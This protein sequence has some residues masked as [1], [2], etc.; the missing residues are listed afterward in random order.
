MTRRRTTDGLPWLALC[1]LGAAVL[2]GCTGDPVVGRGDAGGMDAPDVGLVC[3]TPQTVCANRC[4]DLQSDPTNCGACGRSCADGMVCTAGVCQVRCPAGATVCGGTCVNTQT[5]NANCGACGRPC[6]A[7]QVCSLG[8]CGTTCAASLATCAGGDAGSDAGAAPFCADLANDR[9]NCGACGTACPPGNICVA[10]ACQLSCAAGQ[11][12]CGAACADLQNDNAHCGTCGTACPAGTACVAGACAVSCGAGLAQCGSACVNLQTD[13]THCGACGTACPAG[14]VCSAGACSTTCASPL[15]TCSGTS[16][17]FCANTDL[18]PAHCGSCGTA[19]ALPNVAANGCA[20]GACGV[21]RCSANFGDCDGTAA[22]GCETDTRTALAHCG[23]CGRACAL[24]HATASCAAGACTVMACATGFADCDGVAA[25]GCEVNTG[26]E[27]GN[28]GACG[29][30]CPA[31]QVCSNGACGA[32]CA[33]PLATCTTAGATSCANTQNDPAHCGACNA[34]C[35]LANAAVQTCASGRCTVASC[36][37]SFGDCDGMSANGCETDTRTAVANCGGCGRACSLANATSTCA[38]G[39]CAV[40]A[41]AT[42]FA[43]CDGMAANGCEVA[44]PTDNANCGACGRACGAGQVCSAGSCTATCASPLATCGAGS[45]QFCANTLVDPANCGACGAACSLS[46]AAAT[47]CAAGACTVLRCNALAGD[48]DG[49]ASNG[50]ETNLATSSAHCGACGRACAL[51]NATSS[52]S[53]GG[54]AVTA[55]AANFANCDM[56]AAN[57]CEVNTQSDNANCGG[58]GTTCPAGQLCAG[59]ACTTTCAAPLTLCSGACVNTTNDPMRCGSCTNVCPTPAH[60]IPVC[61]A[62][63]CAF[64]CAAGYGDCDR[65]ASNGCEVDL[66]STAASCGSCTGACPARANATSTCAS[67]TCGYVCSAGAADCDSMAANG[68]E[69]NTNT[70]TNCGGCGRVCPTYANATPTCGS[71]TCGSTCNA[72]F[73]DCDGDPTNGCASTQ[74]DAA[75]CGSCGHACTTGQSCLG[76][77]CISALSCRSIKAANPLA[78]DG[79]YAIDPDGAGGGAAFNV[80]CEMTTD[81]GGWTVMAYIRSNAQWDIPTFMNSGTPGDVAGGFAQGATLQAS[82]ATFTDRIII[83]RRLIENGSDL[84]AQWMQTYRTDGTPVRYSGYNVEGGW[85]YRD[86][87]GYVD[88][89]VDSICS[90]GCSSFRG[91]GMFHAFESGFG[92][93]GTQT[94]NYG[95]RDG[96]NICWM[97]RSGGC[98]VG[99]T[100]CS[101]LTGPGEGVIYAG[102]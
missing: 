13:N 21:V 67:T 80:Y 92:Y 71:G 58:C 22:N 20:G 77:A 34:A 63:A 36:A 18:D 90:H 82:A 48:C 35:A 23:G 37:A 33:S 42:G 51:P 85:S 66:S 94:G 101:L 46:G 8:A 62:G 47:G 102:R 91:L 26:T 40:M 83:Y 78:T 41:C 86:S 3:T 81:G 9:L 30:V 29:T 55:C 2:A 52:C 19:C 87:F 24:P 49:T 60:A 56:M 39:A 73:G 99:D 16:G 32:T 6:A 12:Q 43:D 54:C 28:C 61:A 38:A 65:N 96:N 79:V 68:C 50:C 100:R 75:N 11:S 84:G 93:A 1:V 89:S 74:S 44:L 97:P 25:N 14:Q 70:P 7:G 76:G 53:G 15:S 10:R 27:N 98:N 17:S 72:G 64:V 88:P 4:A 69:V 45:S 5:D 57:G 59:G 95:C 31:G